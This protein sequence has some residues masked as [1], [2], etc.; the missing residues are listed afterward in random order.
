MVVDMGTVK[1]ELKYL[2]IRPKYFATVAKVEPLALEYLSG[3]IKD[4]GKK[5]EILDEFV[6]GYLFRYK[7]VAD[8]I[9]KEGY[10]VIAF[11]LNANEVSY[12]LKTIEKLKRQF[13]DLKIIV[14]GPEPTVNYKDFCIDG[15]DIVYFDNGLSS[16]KEMVRHDL[17][18]EVLGRCTGICY[19]TGEKWRENQGSL[20]VDDFISEPDRTVFFK[21]MKKY[22]IVGKGRFAMLK[23]SFSCP[24]K[25]SFC[26]C[27]KLNSGKYTERPVEK[28]I[29]EIIELRHDR[30]FIIDDDFLVN[31]QRVVEICNALIEKNIRK[32]FMIFARADSIIM[33]RDILPLLHKAGFR[34]FSVGIE[35]VNDEYLKDY[36]KNSTTDTNEEAIDLLNKN[37]ILCNGLFV[38]SH[39]FSQKDFFRLYRF[40]ARKKLKWVLFS[41]ITPY[42]GTEAYEEFKD[43]ILRYIPKRLE[44]THILVK[45]EK[46]SRLLYYIN[47]HMLYILHYPR[48]YYYT[49]IK[50]Y[51][52][53]VGWG[54][55]KK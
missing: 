21:D 7:R 27:K 13:K 54:E 15:I 35:A 26:F 47:F 8:K 41:M 28:V 49:V 20:P 36:N 39:K 3:I 52:R 1:M 34:D 14:G 42:K 53:L 25:C 50:K 31:K 16:F 19:K 18:G 51:D 2:L 4:E 38:I 11:H 32:L 46:M 44:G 40:I 6:H 5:C 43:R 48:L 10:N 30:I 9:K 33:N 12:A 55:E 24:Q 29:K 37:G 22:F 45:P 23:T 17:D